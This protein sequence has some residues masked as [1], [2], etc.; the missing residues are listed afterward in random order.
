[1]AAVIDEFRRH[2][3]RTTA[4]DIQQALKLASVEAGIGRA[5]SP[6]VIIGLLLLL[7]GGIFFA[8]RMSGQ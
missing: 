4:T 2:D 8:L 5:M 1:M 7:A 3:P 6:A